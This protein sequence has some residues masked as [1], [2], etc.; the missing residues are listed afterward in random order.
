MKKSPLISAA[1]IAAVTLSGCS[2]LKKQEASTVNSQDAMPLF[3]VTVQTPADVSLDGHWFMRTVGS[4][5]LSGFDEEWPF[6]EFVPT[7]GR[8]YGNN[9]CN[10]INGSYHVGPKQTLT[11]SEVATSMRLCA[12]D[13]LEY[14]IAHALDAVRSF[15]VTTAKDGSTILSLHDDKNLT[16]MTLR[17]SDIDFLNGPWQVEAIKGEKV[18][19]PDC[20]LIFDVAEGTVSGD[21]GCNMLNGQLVREASVSGSLGFTHL[22]TTRRMCPDISTEQ[23]LLIAL[24]EVTI[25][26]HSSGKSVDLLN[27]SG[28]VIIHL[29]PLKKSDL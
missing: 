3:P 20:R 12:A 21:T 14:P 27:S 29:T 15:S 28:E 10:I 5:K 9:G 1:L 6:L 16:V 2:L 7:E 8:F 4:M 18:E 13:S 26:K 11:L 24:E 22:L 17:K 19:N 25:A 23:A